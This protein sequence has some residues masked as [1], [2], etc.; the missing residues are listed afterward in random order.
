MHT[1]ARTGKRAAV[2]CGGSGGF[3]CVWDRCCAPAFSI[4]AS[5]DG[6]TEAFSVP[7]ASAVHPKLFPGAFRGEA[8]LFCVWDRCRIPRA[9]PWHF[10]AEKQEG[11]SAPQCHC[12]SAPARRLSEE[13]QGFSLHL[14]P[15][16]CVCA[17]YV[18]AL[19]RKNRGFLCAWSYHRVPRSPQYSCV[20]KRGLSLYPGRSLH[21][22]A[23]SFGILVWKSKRCP[24][25]LGAAARPDLLP[26]PSCGKAR[27]F[28]RAGTLREA[29][30]AGGEKSPA[31]RWRHLCPGAFSAA[32]G[33]GR[34][35][36]R[37]QTVSAAVQKGCVCRRQ[38]GAAD[39]VRPGFPCPGRAGRS[40]PAF[41]VRVRLSC[42]PA[43]PAAAPVAA[44][45]SPY[46]NAAAQDKLLP[47]AAPQ[48]K[49]PAPLRRGRAPRPQRTGQGPGGPALCLICKN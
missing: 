43:H 46:M 16:P 33:M 34:E 5:S 48:K 13:K 10:R 20:E 37:T 11:A 26:A 12:A 42:R 19:V 38:C 35:A 17:L 30:V 41:A 32:P 29:A 8:G 2:S 18:G 28:V 9:F 36:K 21:P 31:K 1:S 6:E 24:L 3:L 44:F 39:G 23:L 25:R 45:L 4:P 15:Q 22:L 7:G 47:C 14:K 49:R 27:A 40:L